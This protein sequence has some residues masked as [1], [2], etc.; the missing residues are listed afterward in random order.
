MARTK[1]IGVI[2]TGFLLGASVAS[3]QTVASPAGS[4][5]SGIVPVTGPSTV[6]SLPEPVRPESTPAVDAGEIKTAENTSKVAAGHP[7]PRTTKVVH[8]PGAK[9]TV[10]K[11]SSTTKHVTKA[12]GSA[13]TKQVVAAKQK[14]HVN[15]AMVG[16]ATP[17]S[18][19]QPVTPAAKDAAPGQPLL[20]RV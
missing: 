10:K 3:A 4:T 14:P 18:K 2:V 16:K 1:T 9:N 19:H 17:V 20:P 6:A 13:K 15:H 7:S 5:P 8:K 12:T 11:T